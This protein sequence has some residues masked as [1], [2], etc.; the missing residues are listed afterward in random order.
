MNRPARPHGLMANLRGR[1]LLAGAFLFLLLVLSAFAPAAVFA[2]IRGELAALEGQVERTASGSGWTANGQPGDATKPRTNVGTA[3]QAAATAA[4]P[5]ITGQTQPA[6]QGG[7]G[8]AARA[9]GG[10]SAAAPNAAAVANQTDL[11]GEIALITAV[12][13]SIQDRFFRPLDSRDLLRA[14]WEGARRALTEQRKLPTGIDAPGLTGDRAGDLQAFLAQYRALLAQAGSGVDTRRV[15][16]V[17]SDLM[18]QSVGEQHTVFLTPDTYARFRASLTSD[19]GRVGL[20]ILIQGQSAPFRISSVIPGAPADKAG[21][22]EG[23]ELE[24]IDGRDVRGLDLRTVSDLLRGE[25]GQQVSLSLRRRSGADLPVRAPG[26]I[27]AAATDADGSTFDVK[28]TRAKFT[29][30]PLTMRLLSDGVCVFRLST[31]PVAF[32]VGPTGRTIG[33]DWDYY[34]E[35]CEQAGGKGWIVDLR[36]NGGGASLTQVL[37]RFMDAGPVLVERDRMRGRYEQATDGHL[38]RVQRPLVVLIDGNSASASEAFA[39]AIQEYGRGIVMGRKSA[40]ALNTGNIVQLPLGAGMMVAI[41]EVFTGK[42][43]VPVDEVGVTPDVALNARDGSSVPQEAIDAALHPPA[44]IGPLPAGPST[45]EGV[46]SAEELKRRTTPVLLRA[47]DAGRPEDRVQRGDLA[48]DTLHYYISDYPSLTA[49]RERA[50]RLGWQGVYARWIGS[51]FPPP[52]AVIVGYYK[53]GDGAHKDLREIY[54]PNEPHN[55]PQW[56]EVDS[57]VTLGDETIAQVGVGQNEGRI[58]I[59]WRRG[60]T[61]YTV[62]Q[63]IPPG[64]PQTFDEVARLSKIVDERAQAAGS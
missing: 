2:P 31:F 13:N 38:F 57:P 36:G 30:P 18:T 40:G 19:Q 62:S 34:L 61:I 17:A 9:S 16:M 26:Q 3:P 35:Q 6:G 28:L 59:S 55:P 4:A 53:D 1:A 60:G 52:F 49:A 7:D 63:S 22:K 56:R 32:I 47:E 42:K 37:G 12:Y 58:W 5:S 29:E 48:F 15:A 39:S 25:E 11:D 23:D 20:G 54:E 24:A 43:E 33:E 21:V 8:S 27:P 50:L 64:D 51:G 45:Y 10:P 44:G 41:R 46:L 14:A